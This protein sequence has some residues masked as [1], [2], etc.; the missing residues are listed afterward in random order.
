MLA[1]IM[2]MQA[3]VL[4]L[5]EP[6]NHL[7]LESITALNNGLVEFPGTVLLISQDRQTIDTVAKRVIELCPKGCI[8]RQM[9]YSDY[10]EDAEIEG[11]R[12]RLS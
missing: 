1:R 10:L 4:I 5:D 11:E 6:T 3:N 8:D 9:V 7:D 2:M 12:A